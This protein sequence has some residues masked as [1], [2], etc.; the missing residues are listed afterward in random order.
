MK[1]NKLLPD[2]SIK[3]IWD[4]LTKHDSDVN[5]LQENINELD[6]DLQN[7][8]DELNSN[9]TLTQRGEIQSVS[10]PPKSIV[11]I[12]ITFYKKF[13]SAPVVLC[14]MRS[15]TTNHNYALLTCFVT[16]VSTTGATLRVASVAEDTTFMPNIA[17]IANGSI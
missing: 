11:D 16:N 15:A 3:K 4:R 5:T 9:M 8:I 6:T 14:G 10:V 13:T 7:Q 2:L 17:W 1:T 12:D